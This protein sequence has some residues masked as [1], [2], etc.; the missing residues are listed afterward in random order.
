MKVLGIY[1]VDME[2]AVAFSSYISG[3]KGIPFEIR[4]FTKKEALLSYCTTNEL[5]IL[6]ISAQ[7]MEEE[8]EELPVAQII[9]LSN[10]EDTTAFLEY[11]SI[12]KYQSG[13]GIIREVM[14]CYAVTHNGTDL[15]IP[16]DT[17]TRLV[18][19]YSPVK[20]SQKT[21]FALALANVLGESSSTLYVNLEMF[22]G[23]SKWMEQNEKR[24]VGDLMYFYLQN[25]MKLTAQLQATVLSIHNIDYIPPFHFGGSVYDVETRQWIGLLLGIMKT[26]LYENIVV[27]VGDSLGDVQELLAV[28]HRIF[29]PVDDSYLSQCKKKEF[30][31]FLFRTEY[32]EVLERIQ[33]VELPWDEARGEE[34]SLDALFLGFYNRQVRRIIEQEEADEHGSAV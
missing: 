24:D 28:C 18:G 19:V 2:Y 26:G 7:V 17:E 29:A 20:G 8:F 23:F 4:T 27:D 16:S 22:S 30:E 31:E 12:Y 9:L 14:A 6:L 1:D 11:P 33:Y 13:D 21:A 34:D 15:T 10:G 32:A 5:E 25:P 3:K